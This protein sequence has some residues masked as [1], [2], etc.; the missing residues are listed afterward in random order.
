MPVDPASPAPP[1]SVRRRW[2]ATRLAMGYGAVGEGH[3]TARDGRTWGRGTTG[4][5]WG[6]R[7]HSDTW[8]PMR[9]SGEIFRDEET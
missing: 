5:E 1:L 7:M 2:G 6:G 3:D 9:V 8:T 4:V